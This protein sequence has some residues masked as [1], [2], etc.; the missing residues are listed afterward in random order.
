MAK[1]FFTATESAHTQI[2]G[3]FDFVWPTAAAMWNLRWQVNG[4][5]QAAPDATV[6]QLRARFTDGTDIHGANLRRACIEHSWDEQKETFARFL[7]VNSIAV[8]EGWID[9]VLDDLG[10]NTDALRTALQKADSSANAGKGVAWAISEI[11][12]AESG[13]MK[14]CFYPTLCKGG[15]FAPAH[16]DAMLLCY[17]FFKEL[18]NCDM[19]GGGIAQQRLVAAYT[20]FCVVATPLGLGISEVPA[21][22]PVVIGGKTQVNLRG[23]VGFSHLILKLITTLD[24]ELCRSDASEH[25]FVRRWKLIHS[26]CLNFSLRSAKAKNLAKK[27]SAKAGFP[28]AVATDDL[29]AWLKL[30]RLITY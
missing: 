26:K 29:A 13:V 14:N 4:Y 22:F 23:V 24:A 5:I 19:H 12:R 9:G 7:L 11:T 16:L 3:L 8:Y 28:T 6:E 18:R 30:K 25:V 17:R 10:K 21:H 20:N 27:A 2:T 15:H 1:Y